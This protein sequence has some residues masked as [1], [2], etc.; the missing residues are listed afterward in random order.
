MT[1]KEEPKRLYR[2]QK[3]RMIAGVCGGIGL[4]LKQ[5]PTLIRV[6]AILIT[7]FTGFFPGLIAYII[8]WIIIPENPSE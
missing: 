5:D 7:V 3:E 8:L 1:K 6:L 4:Y 2:S